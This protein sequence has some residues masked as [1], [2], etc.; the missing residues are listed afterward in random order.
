MLSQIQ[1][2]KYTSLYVEVVIKIDWLFVSFFILSIIFY[3]FLYTFLYIY[4]QETEPKCPTVVRAYDFNPEE[5]AAKIE[6]AIKTK[7]KGWC[8]KHLTFALESVDLIL[9]HRL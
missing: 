5:D 8:H 2:T 3:I 9:H 6:T 4:F 7:G 1:Q